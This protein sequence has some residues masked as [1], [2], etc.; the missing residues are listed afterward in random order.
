MLLKL[1]LSTCSSEN[2]LHSENK[3]LF[4]LLQSKIQDNA[5][6]HLDAKFYS[7]EAVNNLCKS[8]S[9]QISLPVFPLNIRSL[10][11]RSREFCFIMNLIEHDFD[12]IFLSKVWSFNSEC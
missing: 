5:F 9:K 7:I 2:V 8:I 11:S 12:V 1:M 10:N 3:E 6:S 4:G